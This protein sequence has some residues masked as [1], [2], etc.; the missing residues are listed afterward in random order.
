M[1]N[2]VSFSSGYMDL[3]LYGSTTS[4]GSILPQSLSSYSC[5][6]NCLLS[7]QAAPQSS[8]L[9]I[10]GN[11]PDGASYLNLVGFLTSLDPTTSLDGMADFTLTGT[12]TFSNSLSS[13]LPAAL[14]L[15]ATGLGALGL[16]GWRR[17]RKAQ[18]AA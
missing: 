16:L 18:A 9:L 5:D 13:P 4:T 2:G 11:S 12:I 6:A 3:F 7:N 1:L 10:A 17:K 14:P 15:F 8:E